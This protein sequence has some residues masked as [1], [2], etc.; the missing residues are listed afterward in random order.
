M[1]RWAYGLMKEAREED[2]REGGRRGE[3]QS[4]PP[5][6]NVWR[7]RCEFC[8][9]PRPPPTTPTASER[10]R[11]GQRVGSR[12]RRGREGGQGPGA[13]L[14]F[15]LPSSGERKMLPPV[16]RKRKAMS[17]EAG[18]SRVEAGEEAREPERERGGR[19]W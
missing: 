19:T 2:E 3:A 10:G 5:S 1:L 13:P 18:A 17:A 15:G 8:V 12:G 16:A 6:R 9:M 4:S 14:A 11:E 7:L